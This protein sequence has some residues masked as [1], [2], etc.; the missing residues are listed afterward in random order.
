MTETTEQAKETKPKA[1]K[2]VKI[3]IHSDA[4]GGDKGDVIL[5][6]NF[7][8][9]QIMRNKEVEI[10]EKFIDCLKGSMI[11]TMVKGEDDKMHPVSVPRYAYTL[12]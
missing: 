6:H 3:T 8:Q 9:I 1:A 2:K 12:G 4:D 10:D 5:V 7:N 11:Q